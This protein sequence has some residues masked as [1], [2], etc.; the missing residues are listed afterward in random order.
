MN[1]YSDRH[2]QDHRP[3][4]EAQHAEDMRLVHLQ[5]VVA[6]E[7]FLE[8]IE[9]RRA[10]ISE[11]HANR[12]DSQGGKAFAFVAMRGVMRLGGCS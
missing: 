4:H 11:H 7:A 8:R 2:D 6:D 5:R 3:E 12:A 1:T 10:D 9:R